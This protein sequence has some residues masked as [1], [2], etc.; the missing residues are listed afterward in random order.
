MRTKRVLR[1]YCD[2][3]S[4]GGF[5]RPEMMRHETTCVHNPNRH[6]SV[7]EGQSDLSE[8]IAIAKQIDPDSMDL[9]RLEETAYRC[10][11]CMLAAIVQARR[12]SLALDPDDRLGWIRFDYKERMQAWRDEE[13]REFQAMVFNPAHFP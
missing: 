8:L 2:H 6:C 10:P 1:Y 9:K 5:R 12:Q 11:A 4:K 13:A 3:C 7:C